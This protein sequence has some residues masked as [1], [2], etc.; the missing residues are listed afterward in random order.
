MPE[1]WGVDPAAVE[2]LLQQGGVRLDGEPDHAFQ[3]ALDLLNQAP[4]FESVID[5]ERAESFHLEAISGWLLL[6]EALGEMSEEQRDTI[7]VR[8]R[9]LG[10]IAIARAF[11][12]LPVA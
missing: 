8:A 9:E 6:G 3:Q 7:V 10:V 12:E 4:L 11:L 5:P 1:E 2:N